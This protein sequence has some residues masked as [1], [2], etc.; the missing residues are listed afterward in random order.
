MGEIERIT[1]KAKIRAQEGRDNPSMRKDDGYVV[2]LIYLLEESTRVIEALCQN[3]SVVSEEAL[4]V[5]QLQSILG[6]IDDENLR[7]FFLAK[8]NDGMKLAPKP[9]AVRIGESTIEKGR[10]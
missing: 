6:E 7:G 5:A 1:S 2:N 4:T 10:A 9:D 8:V 3:K